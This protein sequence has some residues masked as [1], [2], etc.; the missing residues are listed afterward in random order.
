MKTLCWWVK[1]STGLS[2][3]LFKGYTM[4]NKRCMGFWVITG[5]L[6]TGAKFVRRESDHV[7]IVKMPDWVEFTLWFKNLRFY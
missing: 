1:P 3:L 5:A 7:A 4:K 2:T 6:V